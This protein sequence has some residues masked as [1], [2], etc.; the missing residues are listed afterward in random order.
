MDRD[1]FIELIK[2]QD[3]VK[4]NNSTKMFFSTSI[5]YLIVVNNG[6][7]V[8][9]FRIKQDGKNEL[10]LIRKFKASLYTTI[11]TNYVETDRY[12][13][14]GTG[15][16]FIV[17]DKL[18][19]IGKISHSNALTFSK[20]TTTENEKRRLNLTPNSINTYTISEDLGYVVCKGNNKTIRLIDYEIEKGRRFS[21]NSD[22]YDVRKVADGVY[23]AKSYLMTID[24]Y[25]LIDFDTVF[26]L[27]LL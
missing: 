25:S 15:F 2:K 21:F 27:K 6:K 16:S 13:V 12:I 9:I 17:F 3:D 5:D 18:Y 23:Y 26:A 4:I 11:A 8:T 14:F 10:A 19:E 24:D 1:R 22:I 7:D 20:I